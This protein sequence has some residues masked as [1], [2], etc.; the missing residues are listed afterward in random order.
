M[1]PYREKRVVGALSC[2]V[3]VN[4]VRTDAVL[5]S[6][7]GVT[8]LSDDLARRLGIHVS[9]RQGPAAMVF[10]GE[11]K[12]LSNWGE[13]VVEFLGFRA[14]GTLGIVEDLPVGLLLGTDYLCRSPLWINFQKLLIWSRE[15]PKNEWSRVCL[16]P[17]SGKLH[18]M[19]L[20]RV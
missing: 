11:V 10:S 5:G 15:S 4:G 14:R 9:S 16:W 20:V 12:P 1:K 7:S 18:E 6:A 17:L 8:L 2:T 19:F 3:M 13:A